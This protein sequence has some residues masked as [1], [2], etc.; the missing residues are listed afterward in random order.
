MV[1]WK[2][3]TLATASRSA[4]SRPLAAQDSVP[5][6]R[7]FADMM[8]RVADPDRALLRAWIAGARGEIRAAILALE[9]VPLIRPA[10]DNIRQ[11]LASLRC[12]EG[13]TCPNS[14]VWQ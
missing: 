5:L 3:H 1:T 10:L 7:A 8:A 12:A 14:Q 13:S 11:E 9:R 4:I 6:V 2:P